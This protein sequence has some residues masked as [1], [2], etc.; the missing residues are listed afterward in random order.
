MGNFFS[1]QKKKHNNAPFS[2]ER[3]ERPSQVFEISAGKRFFSTLPAERRAI[4]AAF[5]PSVVIGVGAMGCVALQRWLTQ[6]SHYDA[7][8]F[9]RVR[10]LVI[11]LADLPHLPE[12]AAQTYYLSF[13]D[14][15]NR[16]KNPLDS[17]LQAAVLRRLSDW[18]RVNMVDLR[19]CQIMIVGS[20]AE[21]EIQILGALL[22][23]LRSFLT[24]NSIPVLNVVGLLSLEPFDKKKSLSSGEKYA[25]LREVGRF[26]FSG[27]HKGVE[28]YNK[29]TAISSALLDHL[30]LFDK[31]AFQKNDD[32]QNELAQAFGE[33][34]FFLSHPSSR[35]FWEMLKNNPTGAFR[36][37]YFQ[38][39]VNAVGIKTFF[40]PLLE[41]QNY[42]A[43]RLSR[44]VLFGERPQDS[45]EQ[46]VS[47]AAENGDQRVA[48]FLARRWLV[49]Q[50]VGYHPIFDWIVSR[51]FKNVNAFPDLDF[52]YN[53]LYAYKV[54]WQLVQFL[55]DANQAGKLRLAERAF[56]YHVQWFED[57]LSAAQN[58]NAEHFFDVIRVWKKAAQALRHALRQWQKTFSTELK[59]D[60]AAPLRSSW[61]SKLSEEASSSHP[62]Q[63]VNDILLRKQ[64]DAENALKNISGSQVLF[65]LTY[66]A[67]SPLAEVERYYEESVRPEISRAGLPTSAAFRAVRNRLEWWVRLAPSRDPELMVICWNDS[68]GNLPNGQPPYEMCFF[69]EDKQKLAEAVLML[70]S[71][72]FSNY[73][74][75]TGDWYLSRLNE[76]INRAD[77][78]ADKIFLSYD[79][80]E[81]ARFN[82]DLRHYYLAA[83]NK[84]ISGSFAKRFFP[85][86]P[87]NSVVEID[88]YD[89]TRFS[90]LTT[91]FSLPFSALT[92]SQQWY[93]D[94]G[95]ASYFHTYIQEKN[96]ATYED[97]YFRLFGVKT[98]FPPVFVMALTDPQL[99][100]LFCQSLISKIIYMKGAGVGEPP[101][102]QVAPVG[103]FNEMLLETDSSPDALFYAFRKFTLETPNDPAVN[104]NPHN[105]FHPNR[106]FAFL[107]ALLRRARTNRN[108]PSFKALKLEFQ[109]KVL[110]KWLA[111]QDPLAVAFSAV[112]RVELEEPVW[113]GWYA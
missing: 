75:L 5:G 96:A 48:E 40:I 77:G 79:E 28:A 13:S 56:D 18:M 86:Q 29:R 97:R 20:V 106:R 59:A 53:D 70:S 84:S 110:T 102:W 34:L 89:P 2:S 3:W 49:E 52:A 69:Y 39:F 19:D 88:N 63:N 30:F 47:N 38:P 54:S 26:T 67:A 113:E 87:N 14:P 68:V 93:Q 92:V 65:P 57:L 42:L 103:D 10:L 98:L 62:D 9:R 71:T 55:N 76:L 66:N 21:P 112:L 33:I 31:S 60:A 24:E 51:Q 91:H 108:G 94:Y 105:H 64:N 83:K 27:I 72:Q 12:S 100:T 107:D 50:G 101:L 22:H 109:N 32:S 16:E 17:F 80:D 61:K 45:A 41:M 58:A 99:I 7:A 11:S 4:S 78:Q 90:V 25:A 36:E 6:T 111:R 35:A 82:S 74:E 23:V 1:P 44:S 43:A 104:L 81:A 15:A 46:F 85:L 37:R 8:S 95:H 73:D